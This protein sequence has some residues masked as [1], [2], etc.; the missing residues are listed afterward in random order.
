MAGKV[1]HGATL[2]KEK[3]IYFFREGNHTKLYEVLGSHVTDHE[4]ERGT[5]F[6]VWAPNAESVS[7]IGDFNYWSD[8]AHPLAV[9]WDSSGVWEGFVPGIGHGALYKYCVTTKDGRKTE[10]GDPFACWWETPPRSASCVWDLD[11]FGWSDEG[12]M[13]AREGKNGLAAPQAIYEVHIGSWRRVPDEDGRSLSYHEL[14]ASLTEYVKEMG[15]THVEFLPVM[16]HPFY[17]SW[18][19]QT[20]GYFAPSSRYGTPHEFMELVDS[21][22][23]AGIGVIL[24][25]VPSHFPADGYGLS[26]FD[27]T[28][29]FEHEDPR[30]GYH[31]DWKSSIFNYGRNEVRSFLL[32]SARFWLDKYHAD[33]LRVDAVASMLYLDYSRKAGEW[34][35]NRY[36]G[37][38]NIEAIEFLRKMNAVLYTDFKGIQMTAEESTS[39]PMVSHPTYVGGLGFG[40]KWNMGWMH[41]TLSYFGLDPVFRKYH[42]NDLTFGMW[43]AYSEN[44]TLP[45]SHDEVV[46]GKGS[47]YGKMPGD[48]W[49][50]SANLRL[51]LGWQIGHP[52]KKLLFM[53]GEFGQEWEWNHDTSL[54]WHELEY[55]F[56]RGIHNWS[57][58][59]LRYYRSTPALWEGDSQKW[60]FEWID[61]G[62]SDASVL[63][64]IRRDTKGNVLLCVG[65][66]T[67]VPRQ[68]Y[69]IGVPKE[70]F[71][72]EV[73]NSD[74]ESFGGG[75]WG[76]FGGADASRVRM[77][78]RE[79]SVELVLPALSFL[80]FEH[81]GPEVSDGEDV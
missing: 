57:R 51:L 2:M 73:L 17:G 12:W 54:S 62:D 16:E 11:G 77:H 15:F 48:E 35:P 74:G 33:G 24:D 23:K 26:N 31:P 53:G 67:P 27:G 81:R 72:R 5:L 63:S 39:W 60:G 52:G 4:G 13:E 28:C 47:L 71:W 3:D 9:R 76:N 64:F 18:G 68:N 21:L 79:F 1:I 55:G 69:R 41:D 78:G 10:K 40:Y 6:S 44:F 38:E 50:K 61:C 66:F 32:S 34:I 29:L 59:L 22:H 49:R 56:H 37:K 58:E 20:L 45:L 42:Q 8:G 25:W 46:H 30:K 75:N 36:G 7:V 19:Y 43:Y 65:N 80:V 14:S 70:G